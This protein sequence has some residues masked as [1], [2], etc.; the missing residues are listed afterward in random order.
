M[1]KNYKW[2]NSRVD[3]ILSQ[4]LQSYDFSEILVNFLEERYKTLV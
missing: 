3:L 4:G 1:N 2:L